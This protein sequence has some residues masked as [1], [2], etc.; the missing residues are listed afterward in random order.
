MMLPI[1]KAQEADNPATTKSGNATSANSQNEQNTPKLREFKLSA[2]ISQKFQD[3]DYAAA[4]QL[5]DAALAQAEA[6][7]A[8]PPAAAD[9]A[10]P[11][12]AADTAA[13]MQ[14]DYLLFMK[15]RALHLSEKYADAVTVLD[16]LIKDFPRSPWAQRARFAKGA[17]FARQGDFL[18]AE[19]IYRLEAQRLLSLDRKQEIADIYLEFAHAYFQPKDEIAQQPNYQ[20]ALEFYQQALLVG[21]QP[22]TV[23]LLE[24]RIA[25][26]YQLLANLPEAI[27]HYQAFLQKHGSGEQRPAA[28]MTPAQR[29]RDIEARYRLGEAHLASG[30]PV[31][32]RRVW[33]DL[34]AIYPGDK[35]ELLPLAAFTLA[36]TFGIP[37]PSGKEDLEL[38][39]AALEKFIKQYPTHAKAPAAHLQIANSYLNQGRS[40]DAQR[41]LEKFLADKQYEGK[42]ELADAR[43]LLGQALASQKLF[44]QAL[45]AWRDYLA[46]HSAHAAWQ[47]VQQNIINTE[48]LI[49]QEDFNAKKHDS[50][51]QL[52]NEFLAKYPLDSRIPLIM[53][54]FG[55]MHQEDHQ[56][57]QAITEWRK[58]VSKYPQS[59]EASQAQLQ[60]AIITETKLKKLER[61]LEEYKKVTWGSAVNQAKYALARLTSKFLQV[62]TARIYRTTESPRVMLQT[63]N[64]PQITVRCYRIDLETYFRK[65]HLIGGI[66]GL[67]IALIDPDKTFE[68]NIP[69]YAQ[70]E[71]RQNEVEVP[72]PSLDNAA[73]DAAQGGVAGAMAVTIS[74]PTLEA[75]TLVL[76]SDLDIIVKSSRDEVLVFAQ[77]MRTGKPWPKAKVLLSNGQTVFAEG[78]TDDEGIFRGQF[79]QL[80]EANLVRA[81]VTSGPHTASNAINLQ[82]LEVGRSLTDIGY[83]YSDRPAYRAGQVVHI[84]GVIRHAANDEYQVPTDKKCKIEVFDPRNRPIWTEEVQLS[85]FGGLRGLFT[86]PATSPSG[87]YRILVTD[88]DK[89][90]F[91]G[92]FRVRDYKIEPIQLLVETDR[93]IFYRGEEITGKLVARYYYGAPVVGKELRYQ[94]ANGKV[95][96]GRTNDSGEVPFTFPTRD[97]RESQVLPL[98]VSLPERNIAITQ[99]FFLSNTGFSVAVTTTRPDFIGGETWEATIKA[100]DAENKPLAQELTLRVLKQ[101]VVN[102]IVGEQEISQHKVKTDAATGIARQTLKLDDGGTYILR[103]EGTDRFDNTI[104]GQGAVT[105]SDESDTTRLRILADKHTLEVGE[106]A[107]VQIHWRDEPVLALVTFDGAKILDHRLVELKTGVNQF[108]LPLTA[109]LAPNFELAVAVMHD[110]PDEEATALETDEASPAAKEAV[111]A[112]AGA[113]PL[114]AKKPKLVRRFHEARNAFDVQRKLRVSLET[115][116][117]GNAMGP[118]R[119]GEEVELVIKTTDALGNP[120]AA[121]LSLGMIEKSLLDQ[122][123][124]PMGPIVEAFGGAR[125]TSAFRTGSSIQFRYRP[126]TRAI[127]RQLLAEVERRELAAEEEARRAA[128]VPFDAILTWSADERNVDLSELGAIRDTNSETA[129]ESRGDPF[130]YYSGGEVPQN[131]Q[132]QQSANAESNGTSG[133]NFHVGPYRGWTA[134]GAGGGQ[135]AQ[136]G[137]QNQVSIQE[138]SSLAANSAPR[139]GAATQEDFDSLVN[140]IVT[141]TIPPDTDHQT[142][143][144]SDWS[145]LSFNQDLPAI[146]DGSNRGKALSE[147]NTANFYNNIRMGNRDLM[148]CNPS[149]GEQWN[150][151]ISNSLGKNFTVAM[152]DE[153]CR[154]VAAGGNL[155]MNSSGSQE[156]GYWNPQILTD[157]NGLARLT[158]TMPDQATAWS[159]TARGVTLETLAGEA[160]AELTVK[161]DLFGE[162]KL[163]AAFTDGDEVDVLA[164]VH[165]DAVEK[166]DLT[167][168]LR[169]IIGGK[170]TEE[171]KTLAVM[172]KG[173][174]EVPFRIKLQRPVNPPLSAKAAE[175]PADKLPMNDAQPD[176]NAEKQPDTPKTDTSKIENAKPD[177]AKAEAAKTDATQEPTDPLA[178]VLV[179]FELTIN[180]PVADNVP[181][182]ADNPPA[183]Q[184]QVAELT[185]TLRRVVPLLPYGVTLSSASGTTASG[186][187][188]LWVEP[189]AGITLRNPHLQVILGPSVERGLL[190]IL[191]GTPV[192]CHL[193]VLRSASSMEIATSDLLAALALQKLY[194]KT[195][196]AGS[197]QLQAIDARIRSCISQLISAQGDD[198]SWSWSGQTGPGHLF[199]TARVYW[200]LTLA[201]QA[202]Y[203]ISDQTLEAT[204]NYLQSQQTNLAET[205]YETKAV[206][207]HALSVAGQGDFAVA[208]RL[209]RNKAALSPTALVY[210]ALAFA[211]MQRIPVAN[212]LLTAIP[213]EAA[214]VDLPTRRGTPRDILTWNCSGAE[215]RALQALAWSKIAP[216]DKK[217][218]ELVDW[219]MANRSG[220]RWNPEKATGPAALAVCD[221]FAKRQFENEKYTLKVFVNDFLIQELTIDQT[222][223]TAILDV[224]RRLLKPGKQH[225]QLQLTGRGRFT[226]QAVLAG[227][228]P[229][230]ELQNT[231]KNWLVRRT[232]EPAPR[233]LNGREV[234]RGFDVLQGTYSTFRNPLTQLPVGQKGHILLEVHRQN[235]VPDQP[236][237]QLEYLVVTEP[238]P[239]GVSVFET[240][241]QG[242][243][244][245]YEISP[246]AITFY[247][248][249]RRDIGTIQFDVHGYLAG[250]YRAAPT[251]V[252]N[253]Y[254]LDQLA[255]GPEKTLTV[256]PL[257]AASRDEYRFT[258]RELLEYGRHFAAEGNYAVAQPHLTELFSK[259]NLNPDTFRETV[260]LLFAAHLKLGPPGD[261]VRYFELIRERY[262]D[263]DVSFEQILQVAA[264]YEKLGEYERCFM[265]YRATV[266]ASFMRENGVAGFLE[267]Q[268]EFLRSVEVMQRLLAEYPPEP[269]VA[270]TQYALAQRVYSYAPRA[271]DDPKLREKKINRVTL[272][273]QALGMLDNFLTMHP[274]D[275]AADQAAFSLSNALLELQAYSELITRATQYAGRYPQSDFLDSFWYLVAYGHFAKHEHQ[276]AIKMAKKVAET[277]RIDKATGKEI[278]SPNKWQAI[279]ILGQVYHSLGQAGEAVAQYLQVEDRF[280]DAKQAIVYFTRKEIKLPEVTTLK[281]AEPVQVELAYRNIPAVDLKVYKIDLMKFSLLKRNLA[282][283]T[284]INLAGIQPSHAETLELGDGKDYRDLTRQLQLP[285]KEEG[286]YLVVCRGENLHASGLVLISPLVV[287]VQEEAGAGR[288]RVTVKNRVTDEYV[289]Q[290]QTKVIGSRNADFVSGESDLRGVFI[291]DN[292]AGTSTVIAQASDGRYAFFRGT[293]ELGPPPAQPN[294]A[295]AAPAADPAAQPPGSAPGKDGLLIEQLQRGNEMLQQRQKEVLDNN[296][297]APA[298]AA[299][300]AGK[301]F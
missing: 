148:M 299:V 232:Y 263:E 152:V 248:G 91:P 143:N 144:A 226:A 76:Q 67:D 64:I 230:N 238:L 278:E 203:L 117:K 193:D 59:E 195:R 281:P 97:F 136:G 265:L 1:A 69:D 43:K 175:A 44:A 46:K 146:Y 186:D 60:I 224:P 23:A 229:A 116:R 284:Q 259:W 40:P 165:N 68:F 48:F 244:E 149:T 180:A 58:L 98:Q 285:L 188:S 253:S 199:T 119:P 140:N 251:L 174:H 237:E 190:D 198:A 106:Q 75:T 213:N 153:L 47:E 82:G 54:R 279:Y 101:T 124:M 50:A 296:Y 112:A 172:A 241:L 216:E 71:L 27:N 260:K 293:T 250:E 290:V 8:A 63:R 41:V 212:E 93:R 289:N 156:T 4:I 35:H 16:N 132:L 127:N 137:S 227:F 147:T 79:N 181:P 130:G 72:L 5:I 254:Q 157:E 25:R 252:R 109:K 202:G 12:A 255:V 276:A 256:L 26:C 142:A 113:V 208:N 277:K 170:L 210:T 301:A 189:P 204:R 167:V 21:P 168:T 219:L 104:S 300:K 218:G 10:T 51:R 159:L 2:E 211:E 228:V 269:Y 22:E 169:T 215:L 288:V 221:W 61:A 90:V 268:G 6:A 233:E 81:F 111:K 138:F 191:F 158:I 120:L 245:R 66:E 160:T 38:G 222:T 131:Q 18:N 205:D 185:D 267:N 139:G 182:Q 100:L 151:N 287:D 115:Q 200:A 235:L 155:V 7:P 89:R 292:I 217:L 128:G 53:L 88:V 239:S 105:I 275:P 135:P 125:R 178:N 34:L 214:L 24:L 56:W 70:Y 114:P 150:L 271:A 73:K 162:L 249:N 15:A 184:P 171:R 141:R 176:A 20:K 37:N 242:G 45:A 122:F 187:T 87:E 173:I 207:L 85:K 84:R 55:Q 286:A 231:T 283:I 102:G 183:N 261:V 65:M 39:V 272:I 36:Q 196:D 123:A 49:A 62:A 13:T 77:N 294:Q 57:E 280:A 9:Q 108:P 161:K 32:A 78:T 154:K 192:S 220:H 246:G 223:E 209:H 42:E 206:I 262:P 118:I 28:K 240:S 257:G 99:N 282:G 86:L 17:A 92:V 297:K 225:I 110:L 29:D 121:E 258:P 14:R 94:L 129:L 134:G 145:E 31:E 197:P 234:P 291:A 166:G 270:A 33:Q 243:F 96:T 264:A 201:R 11:P 107:S 247:I 126:A 52:W 298:P 30:Q 194:N 74:S 266:E 273:Q 163:P 80:A 164:V 133:F 3:R 179:A 236:A 83:I 295:E 103:A 274:N 19:K 95:V 177:A